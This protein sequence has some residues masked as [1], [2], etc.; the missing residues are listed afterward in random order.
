MKNFLPYA[1]IANSLQDIN[2]IGP[3]KGYRSTISKEERKRRTKKN[4]L[5]SKQRHKKYCVA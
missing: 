4:R 2:D 5:A 3:S 1:L